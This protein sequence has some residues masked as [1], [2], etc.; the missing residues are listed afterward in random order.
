MGHTLRQNIAIQASFEF[1]LELR[2]RYEVGVRRNIVQ[3]AA[4]SQVPDLCRVVFAAR[5]QVMP[6][7]RLFLAVLV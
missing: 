1:T 3:A 6:E 4:C 7:T 5:H 2:F